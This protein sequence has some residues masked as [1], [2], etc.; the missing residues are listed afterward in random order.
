MSPRE[1]LTS[2]SPALK[3]ALKPAAQKPAAKKPVVAKKPAPAKKPVAETAPQPEA[4]PAGPEATA[5][6]SPPP[7]EPVADGAE[8]TFSYKSMGAAVAIFWQGR[9]VVTV[10]GAVGAALRRKLADADEATVQELLQRASG[11]F[12]RGNERRDR[13]RPFR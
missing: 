4:S 9:Q 2:G 6:T 5:A 3:P 13:E 8:D 12:K 1:D 7:P 11:N 10:G